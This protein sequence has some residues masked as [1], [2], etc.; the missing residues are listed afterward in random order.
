[1]KINKQN[2]YYLSYDPEDM[3]LEPLSL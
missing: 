2:K 3:G 1:M